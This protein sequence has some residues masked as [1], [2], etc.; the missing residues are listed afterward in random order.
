MTIARKYRKVLWDKPTIVGSTVVDLAKCF[1]YNFHFNVMKPNF[2]CKQLYSDADSFLYE[3]L[4]GDLFEDIAK[5]LNS[6]NI[7]IFPTMPSSTVFFYRTLKKEMMKFKDEMVGKLIN[8]F[9]CLK[10]KLYSILAEEK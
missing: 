8:E 10:P 1:M 2:E 9:V 3:I 7:S 6:K 4:S 5:I